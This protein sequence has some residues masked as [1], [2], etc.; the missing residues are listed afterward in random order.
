MLRGNGGYTMLE[1]LIVM[2]IMAFVAVGAMSMM[3]SSARCFDDNSVQAFTDTDAAIAMQMIVNDVREAKS[4]N[5]IGGNRLKV[6]FPKK[7]DSGYYDR[8]EPDMTSQI[9]FYLSDETGVLGR[10]G[11]WLW[12]SN[13]TGNRQPLK[14]DVSDLSFEPDTARS[15]KITIVTQN[16]AASGIKETQLTERVVYLRNY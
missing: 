14:K 2:S 8:H 4:V 16:K 12:K 13:S 6:I 7:T 5:I 1:A 10:S 15:V 11:T 3:T 9:E